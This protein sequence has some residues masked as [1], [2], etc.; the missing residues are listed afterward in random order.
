MNGHDRG[1]FPGLDTP[2]FPENLQEHALQRA[3][4]ALR[5]PVPRADLWGRIRANR[6]WRLA[7]AVSV[8]ALCAANLALGGWVTPSHRRPSPSARI[9]PDPEIQSIAD[10]PRLRMAID[11]RPLGRGE[12]QNNRD[13]EDL[14]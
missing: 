8:A 5:A 1:L 14:S 6:G 11:E 3:R 2:E 13:T 4:A 9:A 12:S 7:W 10:L